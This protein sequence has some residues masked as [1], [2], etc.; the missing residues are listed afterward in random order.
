MLTIFMEIN[1]TRLLKKVLKLVVIFFYNY[2]CISTLCKFLFMKRRGR[3]LSLL[4]IIG[5]TRSNIMRMIMLEQLMTFVITVII[6]IAVGIFGSKI[7]LMIVLRLLG[8][9]ISVSIIFNFHAVLETLL[10]ILVAYILIIIQSY[11]LYVNV[12][13]MSLHMILLKRSK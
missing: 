3:E 2:Y 13:F 8:I 6:G 9:N 1:P 7:L 10:L 12:R 5:L 4:Q 11:I